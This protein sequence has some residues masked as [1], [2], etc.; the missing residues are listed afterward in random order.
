MIFNSFS[1]S[2]T[3]CIFIML[4]SL[5]C[6]KL[7]QYKISWIVGECEFNEK[8]SVYHQKMLKGLGIVYPLAIIPILFF[9]DNI[10]NIY[11]YFM[12]FSLSVIGLM[13]D[14][15]NLNFKIKILFFLLIS[16]VFNFISSQEE[17]HIGYFILKTFYFVFLII[18]FN[19]I[20]GINGLAVM[21]FIICYFFITILSGNLILF[22]PLICCTLPY[23]FFNFRGKVGFQG[24]SGSY[25]LAGIIYI[26]LLKNNNQFDYLISV[27]FLFPILLDLVATTL[28]KIFF[29]ENIFKGHKDNIYQR[30]ASLKNSHLFSTFFFNFIQIIQSLIVVY[31]ILNYSSTV[32]AIYF[33]FMSAFIFIIFIFFSIKIHSNKVLKIE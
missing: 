14:K 16:F 25:F 17:I 32:F 20:D 3:I 19:Q 29:K 28:V 8:S 33:G 2:I 23:L 18:F 7:I 22:L 13:D 24:D 15:F 10:L 30:I 31:L 6:I 27:F 5:F 1:L 12:L 4:I 26:I 11:D 9:Y 21:T